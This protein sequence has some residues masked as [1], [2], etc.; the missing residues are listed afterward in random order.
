MMKLAI[1]Q[2]VF[3]ALMKKL[4][5]LSGIILTTVLVVAIIFSSSCSCLVSIFS[6]GLFFLPASILLMLAAVG[7]KG[8][9][10]TPVEEA[11]K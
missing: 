9:E 4:I 8:G 10:K 6:L 11:A 1:A 2:M 7:V 5:I 3:G